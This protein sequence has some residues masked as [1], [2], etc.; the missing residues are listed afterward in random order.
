MARK[1]SLPVSASMSRL[2]AI[3]PLASRIR[4][5]TRGKSTIQASVDYLLGQREAMIGFGSIEALYEPELTSNPRIAKACEFH[6]RMTRV[7]LARELWSHG[8]YIGVTII[9]QVLYWVITTT[10]APDPVRAVLEEIRDH[11][12]HRPGLLIFPLISFGI[13]GA[14]I[15]HAF[16]T[17]RV[18]FMLE[19]YGMAVLPQSNSL[20]ATMRSLESARRQFGITQRVPTNLIEHW[21]RSR[22]TDWLHR[23]PLMVLRVRSQPGSYYENQ[24]LLITRLQAAAGFVSML[25]TLQ[26]QRADDTRR[27]FSSSMIN[28]S[29]T[30][31]VRHYIVLYSKS[32]RQREMDGDCVPMW[33]GGTAF[34][35]VSDLSIELEPGHWSRQQDKA[36]RIFRAVDRIHAGYVRHTLVGGGSS[37]L[38][39]VYRKLFEALKFFRR[40]F[41]PSDGRWTA[42]LSLAIAFEVLTTDSYADGVHNRVVRRAKLLLR[43]VAGVRGYGV[44]VDNLYSARGAL[45]H[46]GGSAADVDISTAQR[47]FSHCLVAAAERVRRVRSTSPSPMQDLAGDQIR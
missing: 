46:A 33:L 18:E 31:N 29:Q 38:G 13:L 44:A 36:D 3:G 42:V 6:F 32:G 16:T 22:S 5:A 11:G 2:P 24:R 37:P 47:A 7:A 10:A 23:N 12:L 34:A 4:A 20:E 1:T 25:S 9:D 43:G 40:S 45:V 35:D 14:G 26:P 15:L 30:L 28:N 21:L 19:R 8:M 41:R 17:A 27:L 39:R